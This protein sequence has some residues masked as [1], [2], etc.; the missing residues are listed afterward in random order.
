MVENVFGEL[1]EDGF[2]FL[3]GGSLRH[4]DIHC[5]LKVSEGVWNELKELGSVVFA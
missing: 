2:K 5:R 4:V 1:W 3:E